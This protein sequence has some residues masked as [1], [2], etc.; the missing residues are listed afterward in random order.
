[1]IRGGRGGGDGDGA[2]VVVAGGGG[3]SVSKPYVEEVRETMWWLKAV[4]P[5]IWENSSSWLSSVEET[6]PI[7]H[8]VCVCESVRE[9]GER[10]G[11]EKEIIQF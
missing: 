7:A 1:M 2:T 5:P 10:E 4:E 3:S 6:Q 11:R 8:S 9:R